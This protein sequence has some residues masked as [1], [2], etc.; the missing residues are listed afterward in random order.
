MCLI[1]IY[2]FICVQYDSSI[3]S[4]P[5]CV[6]IE[7]LMEPFGLDSASGLHSGCKRKERHLV[8][9]HLTAPH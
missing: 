3:L 7:V 1:L 8:R 5:L 9:L 6:F 2:S 4:V